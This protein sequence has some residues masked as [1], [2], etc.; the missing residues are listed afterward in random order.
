MFQ[1]T[2]SPRMRN[3]SLFIWQSCQSIDGVNGNKVKMCASI[4]ES[5]KGGNNVH[6]VS[7]H[8]SKNGYWVHTSLVG[9]WV[10]SGFAK[11]YEVVAFLWDWTN[12]VLTMV[13]T[14]LQT[15][16]QK[17]QIDEINMEKDHT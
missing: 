11:Q 17:V 10:K 14:R 12:C 2:L 16:Q 8:V 5:R 4:M 13:C 6:L 15:L 9:F 1:G 7:K 3:Q